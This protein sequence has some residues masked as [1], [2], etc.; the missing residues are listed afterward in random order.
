M[1]TTLQPVLP[2]PFKEYTGTILGCARLPSVSASPDASSTDTLTTTRRSPRAGSGAGE[3]VQ[4]AEFLHFRDQLARDGA[5]RRPS[6]RRPTP[7]F[8]RR[9]YRV[10]SLHL[11]RIF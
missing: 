2:S 4:F 1:Q 7:L 3:F 9:A 11:E 6:P 8:P 10:H 5:G